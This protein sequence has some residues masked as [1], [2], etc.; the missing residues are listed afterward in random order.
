MEKGY[1]YK[2]PHTLQYIHL[3]SCIVSI[4]TYKAKTE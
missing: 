2:N 1:N 4:Y 3:R